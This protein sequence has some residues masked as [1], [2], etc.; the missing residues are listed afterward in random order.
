MDGTN[1]RVY[2]MEYPNDRQGFR[3][4]VAVICTFELMQ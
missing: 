1:L 3:P 4:R 2:N